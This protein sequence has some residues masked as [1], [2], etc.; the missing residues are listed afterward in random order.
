MLDSDSDQ[1]DGED[2]RS[3]WPPHPLA[4]VPDRWPGAASAVTRPEL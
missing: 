1:E 2:R 4:Q 3:E